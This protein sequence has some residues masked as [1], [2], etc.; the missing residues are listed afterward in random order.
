M[1]K[2]CRQTD[3]L[4]FA[5]KWTGENLEEI[6]TLFEEVT[7]FKLLQDSINSETLYIH[8]NSKIDLM[9]VAIGD[10]IIKETLKENFMVMSESDFE[11]FYYVIEQE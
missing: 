3:P 7:S 10:Y 4:F 2:E 11:I 6:Q 9:S 5:V 1:I 8:N